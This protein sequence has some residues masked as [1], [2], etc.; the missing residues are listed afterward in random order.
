MNDRYSSNLS[1]LIHTNNVWIKVTTIMDKQHNLFSLGHN[2]LYKLCCS[3]PGILWHFMGKNQLILP[4]MCRKLPSVSWLPRLTARCLNR[5]SNYKRRR[6]AW[7]LKGFIYTCKS[8]P[9]EDSVTSVFLSQRFTKVAKMLT[10]GETGISSGTE[11]RSERDQLE[12][13]RSVEGR[14]PHKRHFVTGLS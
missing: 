2:F 1:V 6:Q 5:Q 7:I 13:L 8:N 3:P 12:H 10:Q 4:S 14:W 11:N 9:S